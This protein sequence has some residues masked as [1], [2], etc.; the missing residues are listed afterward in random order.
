ML[1]RWTGE[2]ARKRPRAAGG[3]REAEA[4]RGA[5]SVLSGT[6]STKLA[7][8]FRASRGRAAL[9]GDS[10]EDYS[11]S[12]SFEH[13]AAGL[14]WT[15]LLSHE[16]ER[17]LRTPTALGWPWAERPPL[18]AQEL[19]AGG[20]R[21]VLRLVGTLQLHG[22][23]LPRPGQVW[24]STKILL[25]DPKTLRHMMSLVSRNDFAIWC[26]IYRQQEAQLIKRNLN[27]V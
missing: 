11:P 5:V 26:C 24:D 2:P 6:R 27:Q 16:G 15:D 1:P 4:I 14:G 18:S 7:R 17:T 19:T 9:E 20:A 12:G 22:L 23:S 25:T 8:R 3:G 10:V 21:P 13:Q